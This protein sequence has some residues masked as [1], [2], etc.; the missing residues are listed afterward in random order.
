MMKQQKRFKKKKKGWG[1]G[2]RERIA[3]DIVVTRL[4]GR[5]GSG[6]TTSLVTREDW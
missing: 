6:V 3:E 2:E 1:W 4:P 5:P